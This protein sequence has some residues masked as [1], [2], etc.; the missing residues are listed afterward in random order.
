[1]RNLPAS[2]ICVNTQDMWTFV[3]DRFFY[4]LL[5]VI[6]KVSC[7]MKQLEVKWQEQTSP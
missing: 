3:G 1:M 7:E 4:D 6:A 2:A 5:F